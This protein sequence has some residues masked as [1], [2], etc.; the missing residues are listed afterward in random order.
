MAFVNV[1]VLKE[2][3]AKRLNQIDGI[4]M[5]VDDAAMCLGLAISDIHTAD[6]AEVK[7]GEWNYTTEI[8]VSLRHAHWNCSLCGAMSENGGIENYCPNCGAKM[9][10]RNDKKRRPLR[11]SRHNL[12]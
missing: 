12:H 1:E 2:K 7:H 10:G 3:F 4:V 9:D 8:G 6:V 11:N 5:S